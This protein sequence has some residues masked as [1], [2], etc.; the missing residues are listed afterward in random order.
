MIVDIPDE[1][2]RDLERAAAELADE[3]PA[4]RAAARE[5]SLRLV[6]LLDETIASQAMGF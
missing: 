3:D 1:L 6:V 4:T 2:V 5:A